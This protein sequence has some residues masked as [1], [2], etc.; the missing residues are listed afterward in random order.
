[1]HIQK[2]AVG[3]IALAA[4]LVCVVVTPAAAELVPLTGAIW[5]TTGAG[6]K[7]DANIYDQKCAPDL[8]YPDYCDS[9]PLVPFLNGGPNFASPTRWVPDGHYYFQVTDPSG[10]VLLSNDDIEC[11]RFRVYTDGTGVKRIE[12]PL[13]GNTCPHRTCIDVY[14]G[15]TTIELCPYDDTPNNGNEYKLWITPVEAYWAND[16]QFVGRYSKTDNFKVKRLAS[17]WGEK[18][19]GADP[20]E[21]VCIILYEVQKVRGQET[22]VEIDR[23]C[24]NAAGEFSFTNLSVGKYA[25]DEDL[26]CTDCG[27]D[28]SDCDRVSPEGPIYFTITKADTGGRGRNAEPGEPIYIGAFVN[29][30][31]PPPEAALRG[32]KFL[33]VD[34]DGCRDIATEPPLSGWTFCVE[35][36]DGNG[37]WIP[38]VNVLG[39]P[40]PCQTTGSAGTYNFSQLPVPMTYRICETAPPGQEGL[41]LQTGPNTAPDE[42][43]LWPPGL[44]TDPCGDIEVDPVEAGSDVT[45]CAKDGCYIVNFDEMAPEVTQLLNLN[46]GNALAK[47]CVEKRDACTNEPL[48]GFEFTLYDCACENEVTEDA[49]GNPIGPI[50]TG[51]DDDCWDNLLGGSYCVVETPEPGWIP[52]SPTEQCVSVEAGGMATV[53]FYNWAPCMGLTPG[54]WKNWRNHYTAAQFEILL[55]GTIAP[56]IAEADE[57]FEHWDASPGDE[58]TIVKAFLLA[59]QLTLNLTQ[60]PEL[61][62]PSEGSLVPGCSLECYGTPIILADAVEAALACLGDGCSRED[63][64]MIKNWL[65]C[66]AESRLSTPPCL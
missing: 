64:L 20:L 50:T 7:V 21:G 31:G 39:D 49:L 66:F 37:S 65:A 36:K 29:D 58:L 54:Y 26:L 41:W 25:V 43:C 16:E 38:A 2:Y 28:H 30:C 55:A 62:N 24:T 46:F 61:P 10:K 23:T 48:D 11:R 17:V 5:T 13:A 53:T 22:L 1:M 15:N 18:L 52:V 47:L 4:V 3:L 27:A 35:M 45:V 32:V 40:V 44:Y 51:G 33:D 6:E 60:H 63:L 14:S 59:N 8:P 34:Q 57:I 9:P 12:Y 19:D 56:S 42:V